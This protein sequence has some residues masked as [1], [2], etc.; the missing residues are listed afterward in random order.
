MPARK[1][2]KR[3]ERRRSRFLEVSGSSHGSKARKGCMQAVQGQQ[4]HGEGHG[5]RR[6]SSQVTGDPGGEVS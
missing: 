3:K 1:G 5:E 4:R 2:D 6:G